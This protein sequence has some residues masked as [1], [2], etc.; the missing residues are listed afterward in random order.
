VLPLEH[1]R[2]IDWAVRGIPSVLKSITKRSI[3]GGDFRRMVDLGK[4]ATPGGL[5]SYGTDY[6]A[7]FRRAGNYVGRILNGTAAADLAV[8][9]PAKFDLI[10]NL[11]TAKAVGFEIPPMLIAR[12]NAVIEQ[13]TGYGTKLPIQ[14]VL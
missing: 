8:E 1:T 7:M 6:P 14:N 2:R 9:Q 12:A 13:T 4:C 5:M 10:I 3:H 11:K